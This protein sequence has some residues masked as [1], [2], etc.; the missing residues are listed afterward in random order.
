ML[1]VAVFR[2]I[3]RDNCGE[4]V[5]GLWQTFFVVAMAGRGQ[6]GVVV[7]AVAGSTTTTSNLS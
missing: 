7:V 4:P 6:A 2:G 3:D 1:V 5:V